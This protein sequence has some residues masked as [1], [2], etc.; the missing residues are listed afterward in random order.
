MLCFPWGYKLFFFKSSSL[1]SEFP[2]FSVCF[3]ISMSYVRGTPALFA[4]TLGTQKCFWKLCGSEW[5]LLWTVGFSAASSDAVPLMRNH[6]CQH[7]VVFTWPDSVL[8]GVVVPSPAWRTW[9]WY[10]RKRLWGADWPPHLPRVNVLLF[11]CFQ[12]SPLSAALA[13]PQS[14]TLVLPFL[15]KEPPRR[16]LAVASWVLSAS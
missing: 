12:Q 16:H 9:P 13:V 4:H 8:H 5:G 15:G 11:S 10:P 1:C 3:S 14:E 7:R 6:Q 2:P